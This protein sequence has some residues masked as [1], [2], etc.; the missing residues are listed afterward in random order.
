MISEKKYLSVN[1]VLADWSNSRCDRYDY[2]IAAFCG[3]MAGLIDVFFVGDPL[4][5][6]I[7]KATDRAADELV[8]KAAGFFWNAD[9][10]S[11]G[12]SRQKPQ[13]LE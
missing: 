5:S 2:L 6:Q 1:A 13:T 10:R 7:G 11:T 4:T 3:G 9:P 12:K 8:K